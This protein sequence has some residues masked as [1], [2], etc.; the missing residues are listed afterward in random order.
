MEILIISFVLVDQFYFYMHQPIRLDFLNPVK[1]GNISW[2]DGGV[3]SKVYYFHLM[4]SYLY[5]FNPFIDINETAKY[6]SQNNI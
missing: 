4:V 3:V 6:L 5:S 2:E 1:A